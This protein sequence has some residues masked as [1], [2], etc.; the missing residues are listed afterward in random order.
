MAR[1]VWKEYN[2]ISLETRRGVFT[3]AQM[4]RNPFLIFF[5]IFQTG[6]TWDGIDLATVPVL[7]CKA[8]T[9]QFLARSATGKQTRI[10]PLRPA[11]LPTLWI[12]SAVHETR[13]LVAWENTPG[14]R[15]FLTLGAGGML[16]EKDAYNHKGGPYKHPSG[17]YDAIIRNRISPTDTETI[18]KYECDSLAVFP[19]TNERLYQCYLAGKNVDPDKSILFDH[20]L[21]PEYATYIDIAGGQDDARRAEARKFFRL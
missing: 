9:R 21:P 10:T 17:V 4:S 16:V 2:V 1:I 15:H 6:D 7:F 20:P 19:A 12:H 3:L 13:R 14:E 18:E 8:V 5:N 11:T